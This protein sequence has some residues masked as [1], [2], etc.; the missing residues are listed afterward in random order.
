MSAK[1]GICPGQ[2]LMRHKSRLTFQIILHAF[3]SKQPGKGRFFR[4]A[5]SSL[6]ESNVD[7]VPRFTWSIANCTV[8]Q[9]GPF[10]SSIKIRLRPTH[11]LAFAEARKVLQIAHSPMLVEDSCQRRSARQ[12]A[13]SPRQG[14]IDRQPAA[15][16]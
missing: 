1:M 13:V 7:G 16:P 10:A 9:V 3:G 15:K 14:H 2:N 12:S 8:V 11:N 6:L 5:A 4:K